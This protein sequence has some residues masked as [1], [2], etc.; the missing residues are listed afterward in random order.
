MKNLLLASFFIEL[1]SI[2]H[3]FAQSPTI[4][5]EPVLSGLSSPVF[6]VQRTRW[7]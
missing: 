2:T 1:V 7:E 5:L 6:V 4:L 3:A